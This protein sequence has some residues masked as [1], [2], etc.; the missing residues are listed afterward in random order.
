MRLA[1]GTRMPTAFAPRRSIDQILQHVRERERQVEQLIATLAAL[2]VD[3]RRSV[4]VALIAFEE[5]ND[6]PLRQQ[7]Q[8]G[9]SGRQRPYSD[10]V[11]EFVRAHPEGVRAKD[12]AEAK[13]LRPAAASRSLRHAS[14]RGTIE[15]RDRLWFP[16]TKPPQKTERVTV[17]ALIY[18]VFAGNQGPFGAMALYESLKQ[19]QPNIRRGTVDG[20]IG[21]MKRDN[22]LVQVGS[23][24]NNGGLYALTTPTASDAT[25]APSTDST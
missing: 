18:R 5:K 15:L 6:G 11:E 2:D 25:P 20:E 22:L 12:V 24:E 10:D 14:R 1:M 9:S 4:L 19:I 16:T 7:P 3:V 23:G 8:R 13:Q 17:R 21:R